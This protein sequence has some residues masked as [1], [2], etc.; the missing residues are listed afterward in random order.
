MSGVRAIAAVT[1]ALRKRI[2]ISVKSEISDASVTTLPPDRARTAKEGHQLNLFLYQTAWNPAFSNRGIPWKTN[3]SEG[4]ATPVALNLRYLLTAYYGEHDE[5]V[6]F[7]TDP[8]HLKATHTVLGAALRVLHDAP[9]LEAQDLTAALGTKDPPDNVFDVAERA[10]ISPLDLSIEEMSKLWSSFQTNYRLSIAFEVAVVLIESAVPK[11]SALPVLT[12]GREDEGPRVVTM[13]PSLSEAVPPLPLPA[14]LLGRLFILRGSGLNRPGWAIR[15]THPQ[16]KKSR[17]LYPQPGGSE[18]EITLLLPD[19]STPANIWLAGVCTLA[20]ITKLY[21]T[22][23]LHE[24]GS[25]ELL[26][27]P[28]I[29]SNEVVL[30]VA[31]VINGGPFTALKDS[32]FT[33]PLAHPVRTDQRVKFLLNDQEWPVI[34]PNPAVP[35]YVNSVDAKLTGLAVGTYRLRLRVGGVDSIPLKINLPGD[36]Q[37]IPLPPTF[38]VNQILKITP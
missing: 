34:M 13:P 30:P 20:A 3:P 12:R 26:D 22:D 28:L 2:E 17:V 32:T 10:R 31:P 19:G 8:E 21:P 5:G 25:T 16:V 33:L 15:L 11:K 37:I 14:A 1:A 38:D 4:G 29:S 6:D 27:I 36:P 23:I 7:S 35:Q 9:L 18:S 24:P